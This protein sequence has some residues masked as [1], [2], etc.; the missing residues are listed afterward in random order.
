MSSKSKKVDTVYLFTVKNGLYYS[1]SY[2]SKNLDE[3]ALKQALDIFGSIKF[4]ETLEEPLTEEEAKVESNKVNICL[5]F[6][7]GSYNLSE[8][9]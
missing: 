6:W 3:S 2:F 5:I 8:I 1:S 4:T 7:V 9:V